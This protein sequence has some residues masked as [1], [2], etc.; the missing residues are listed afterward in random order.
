MKVNNYNITWDSKD[1]ENYKHLELSQRKE[2]PKQL[3][4]TYQ[5]L[6]Q[7][8]TNIKEQRSIELEGKNKYKT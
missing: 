1:K 2:S 8:Q 6:R 7:A 5:K 3:V 4:K